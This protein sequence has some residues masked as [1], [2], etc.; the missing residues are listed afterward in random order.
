[1][2]LVENIE[3]IVSHIYLPRGSFNYFDLFF[4][5]NFLVFFKKI[6]KMRRKCGDVTLG[7]HR[8]LIFR[9]QKRSFNAHPNTFYRRSY[10][11]L[12]DDSGKF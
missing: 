11:P 12:D 8:A 3:A 5:I 10:L 7:A 9:V 4:Y 2:I 1:M 6:L